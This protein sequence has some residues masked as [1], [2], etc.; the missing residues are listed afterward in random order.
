MPPPRTSV[1]EMVVLPA[2]LKLGEGNTQLPQLERRK[3][4]RSQAGTIPST[5]SLLSI[6]PS[7][8]PWKPI[9]GEVSIFF[10]CLSFFSQVSL[11]LCFDVRMR[12]NNHLQYFGQNE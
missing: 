7:T 12:V 1:T 2:P 11:A 10:G 9:L 8:L 6:K 5:S 3:R 4:V